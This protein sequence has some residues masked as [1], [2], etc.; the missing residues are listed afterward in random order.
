MARINDYLDKEYY[1]K[2]YFNILHQLKVLKSS[3]NKTL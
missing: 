2:E 3:F 1:L